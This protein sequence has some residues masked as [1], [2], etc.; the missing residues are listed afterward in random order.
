MAA[1]QCDICGGKLMGRPGGIFECDSC[2]MEYD[3]AWAKAK[4][5]EIKGT[6]KVEGTVEVTGTVKVDGAVKVEGGVTVESLL[7]RIHIFVQD[8]EFEQ[9]KGLADQI[10]NMDPECGEAYLWLLMAEKKI[11]KTDDLFRH[12][13]RYLEQLSQNKNWQKALRYSSP[14]AAAQLQ[15]QYDDTVASFEAVNDKL[16]QRYDEIQPTQ[17]LIHEFYGDGGGLVA[18]KSD[19]TVYVT[20]GGEKEWL[21]P[22]AKW[23]GI[24]K[25]YSNQFGLLL[26]LG[27]DGRVRAVCDE[28]EKYK[29]MLDTI[30]K[31]RN[32]TLLSIQDGVD[33]DT[34]VGLRSDGT[35]VSAYLDPYQNE[36]KHAYAVTKKGIKVHYALNAKGWTDVKHINLVNL[37]EDRRDLYKDVCYFVL[38]LTT[39]GRIRVSNLSGI[40]NI[41]EFWKFHDQVTKLQNIVKHCHDMIYLFR[42]GSLMN[43]I[44]GNLF[45]NGPYLDYSITKSGITNIGTF[46]IIQEVQNVV[47]ESGHVALQA[48]GNVVSSTLNRQ[49][50]A[51][52]EAAP[53]KNMVAVKEC[54]IGK[55][56]IVGLR[57]DGVVLLAWVEKEQV[58]IS[59]EEWKLFDSLTTLEQEREATKQKAMETQRKQE[60]EE[61]RRREEEARRKAAEQARIRAEQEKKKAA[62]IA[63]LESERSALQTELA[64]LK[65]L[66]TGKRRKEIEAKLA[67]IETELKEL[68]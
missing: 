65:G 23:E 50:K 56:A 15:K 52:V 18:L 36:G 7:K 26:G 17:G 57:E 49:A 34:V 43:L 42:D 33:Y 16:Q 9:I 59:V 41:R 40:P 51:V 5:Q 60:E 39:D 31:W 14:E 47:A 38:G 45:S 27:W 30:A 48:N 21:M 67:Q 55:S 63:K 32:I 12:D 25:L 11:Q 24:Q 58:G 28:P 13:R 22:A 29:K 37:Y 66:F 61:A 10:L 1:L 54:D 68:N 44:N 3:T 2:G 6:V 35:L 46:H 4:V 62:A 19:G 20:H 64:N 53:W 8:K